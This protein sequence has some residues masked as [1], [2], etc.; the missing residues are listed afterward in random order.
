VRLGDVAKVSIRPAQSVIYR[1]GDSRRID[2]S[3]DV[4]GP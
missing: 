3:A 2:V 1:E 4:G